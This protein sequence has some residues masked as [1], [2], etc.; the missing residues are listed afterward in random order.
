MPTSFTS[1]LV[2]FRRPVMP[3]FVFFSLIGLPA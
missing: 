2:V 1:A 3:R